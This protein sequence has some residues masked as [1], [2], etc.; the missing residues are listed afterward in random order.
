MNDGSK[1]AGG[2]MVHSIRHTCHVANSSVAQTN[3]RSGTV[4][5]DSQ[6]TTVVEAPPIEPPKK[7]EGS[8]APEQNLNNLRVVLKWILNQVVTSECMLIL[9]A[10]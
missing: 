4:G 7:E 6:T 8:Q 1:S 10:Y 5:D 3:E 9:L 2:S